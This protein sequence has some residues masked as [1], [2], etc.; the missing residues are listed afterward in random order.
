MQCQ[1]GS[2][3]I[4]EVSAV[5]MPISTQIEAMIDAVR[6]SLDLEANVAYTFNGVPFRVRYKDVI[7]CVKEDKKS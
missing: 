1:E 6:M 5:L 3:R 2:L 7:S 4:E